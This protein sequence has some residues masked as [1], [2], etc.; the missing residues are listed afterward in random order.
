MLLVRL[1]KWL[2]FRKERNLRVVKNWI[3]YFN[4][5]YYEIVDELFYDCLINNKIFGNFGRN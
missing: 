2:E 1:K 5:Q 3:C 4:W